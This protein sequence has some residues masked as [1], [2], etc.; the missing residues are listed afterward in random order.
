MAAYALWEMGVLLFIPALRTWDSVLHHFSVVLAIGIGMF[1]P[2]H[3]GFYS[4]YFVGMQEISSVALGIVDIFKQFRPLQEAYPTCYLIARA[5]FAV[6]F[7][8]VR[9]VLWLIFALHYWRDYASVAPT[10]ELW[11]LFRASVI[12]GGNVVLTVLQLIWGRLVVNGVLKVIIKSPLAK[13]D[14]NKSN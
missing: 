3:N 10:L 4:P 6:L 5:T 8:L 12:V 11:E 14:K 13:G 9:V 7:V 1:S 2:M